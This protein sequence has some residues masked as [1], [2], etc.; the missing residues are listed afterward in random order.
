MLP[1]RRMLT[2]HEPDWNGEERNEDEIYAAIRYLEPDPRSADEG[3]ASYDAVT[4]N[5]NDDSGVVISIC[6]Y[7]VVAG[8]LAVFWLYLR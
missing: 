8:C 6:L 2:N 4:A 5:Q 1:E 3:L 7:I